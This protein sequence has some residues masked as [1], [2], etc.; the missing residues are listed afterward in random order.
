MHQQA[1]QQAS[2][3][4]QCYSYAAAPYAAECRAGAKK[5]GAAVRLKRATAEPRGAEN[6][7][8]HNAE[9]RPLVLACAALKRRKRPRLVL[10][11][12]SIHM[13]KKTAKLTRGVET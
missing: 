8:D 2:A 13:P 11:T 12:T 4:L 9:G 1:Q 5:V 3:A 10:L 7:G 6:R